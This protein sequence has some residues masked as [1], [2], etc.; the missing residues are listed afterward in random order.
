MLNDAPFVMTDNEKISLAFGISAFTFRQQIM[1][2][3]VRDRLSKAPMRLTCLYPAG[4][5]GDNTILAGALWEC[6]LWL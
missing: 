1:S 4:R 2:P 6:N 5:S 3:P